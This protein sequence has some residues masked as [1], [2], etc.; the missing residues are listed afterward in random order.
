MIKVVHRKIQRD[1]L[2]SLIH[3]VLRFSLSRI[4]PFGI[5][6]DIV[7]ARLGLS[8]GSSLGFEVRYGPFKGLVVNKDFVWGKSNLA[9][10]LLGLYEVE[11]IS[12]ISKI[13]LTRSSFIEVGSADGFYAAGALKLLPFERGL[14]FESTKKGRDSTL[15]TLRSNKVEK[16]FKILEEAGV[17]FVQTIL[18]NGFDLT[19]S[20]I[21]CDIEGG[22]FDLFYIETLQVLRN[23]VILIE[24]HE[25]HK[26]DHEIELFLKNFTQYFRVEF[27][28]SGPRDLDHITEIEHLSDDIRWALCSEGRRTSM[29]WLLAT[30]K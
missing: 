4:S 5:K 23:S 17:D 18:A 20:L 14:F 15:N 9:T 24:L 2:G 30:P 7:R 13:A 6:P 16:P 1:G 11:V 8:L 22:E 27:F 29:R 19:D 26:N 25:F 28:K 12:R 10:M 21:L 3:S